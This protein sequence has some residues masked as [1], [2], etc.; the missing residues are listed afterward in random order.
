MPIDIATIYE[1]MPFARTL[2]MIVSKLDPGEVVLALDWRPELLT[3]GGVLHGGV[4]MALA[5][6][7][8]GTC[9]F[10]NLPEG[11]AGTSTIE[12]KTNFLSGVRDGRVIA[13]ARPLHI[14]SSTI[15]IETEL[16]GDGGRLVAKTAQTQSVLRQRA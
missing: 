12:S 4:L 16:R 7:A 10:L 2:G 1:M 15:V 13:V 5:D 8:G 9:A 3:A 14:G 6:S 11:A